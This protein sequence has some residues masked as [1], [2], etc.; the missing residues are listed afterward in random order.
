MMKGCLNLSFKTDLL[1]Q[2]LPFSLCRE[3]ETNAI[4][5]HDWNP[6]VHAVII[7]VHEASTKAPFN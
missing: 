3:L 2:I 5:T 6:N 4:N 1:V 7:S